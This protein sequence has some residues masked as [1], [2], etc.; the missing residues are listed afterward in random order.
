MFDS[1]VDHLAD[2]MFESRMFPI[3][4]ADVCDINVM[5]SE[6]GDHLFMSKHS[7]VCV[8]IHLQDMT[9]HVLG[10]CTQNTEGAIES[11]RSV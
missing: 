5:V 4:C 7:S 10:K 11:M 6:V 1:F 3:K 9:I 2:T 8:L